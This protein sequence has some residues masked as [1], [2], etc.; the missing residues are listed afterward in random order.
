MD[1]QGK[2]IITQCLVTLRR[3]VTSYSEN[4]RKPLQTS[5]NGQ[6]L[7]LLLLLL[8]LNAIEMTTIYQLLYFL[9]ECQQVEV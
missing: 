4:K 5:E 7:L 2:R 6:M 8:L 3:P 9:V 1:I